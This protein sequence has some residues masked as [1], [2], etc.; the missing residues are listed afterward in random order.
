M[1]LSR[2][3]AEVGDFSAWNLR[4]LLPPPDHPLWDRWAYRQNT[5]KVHS[6][7][8]SIVFRWLDH[9]WEPGAP[10]I[11]QTGSGAGEALTAAVGGCVAAL[12]AHFGGTA[13]RVMLAELRP[14]ARI[15]PHVD[16]GA[17]L[18]V[19]HR[20]HIPVITNPRVEFWIEN[21]LYSLREGIAYEF[22][23][24]RTHA[25]ANMGTTPRVHLI[26]DVLAP[27]V[28]YTTAPAF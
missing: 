8:R 27:A 10:L 14:G 6:Q 1:K 13:V 4:A 7:T 17:A 19:P 3:I 26:C 22:D 23:N 15:A 11:V 21:T 2:P 24:T 16:R 18:V 25:V 5:Y 9:T 12:E 28:E 20:C